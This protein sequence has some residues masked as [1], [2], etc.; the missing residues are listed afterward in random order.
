MERTKAQESR[1][2][3]ERLYI[4]MRHLFNRGY[5]KPSGESGKAIINALLTL[6]PEIYGSMAE[7]EKVELEGLVYAIDRLPKGIEECRF[8]TL[9]SDEGLRNASFEVI[10]PSKR[11]RNCFRID[12][13]QMFIEVTRG[14]SEIYDILAH[15]T[16][17]FVEAR[18]I[19]EKALDAK[20]EKTREWLKIE[21]IVKGGKPEDELHDK[22]IAF[23]YLGTV[24]ARTYDEVEKAYARFQESTGQNSG[25]FHVIYWL[26]KL[27]I[28]EESLGRDRKINFS[29]SLRERIGHH[30]YGERWAANIKSSLISHKLF[31]R[32]LHIISANL[33][34]VMNSLYAVGALGKKYKDIP[35]EEIAVTLSKRENGHLREKVEDYAKRH[36]LVTLSDPFGTNIGV[37]IIDTSKLNLAQL[38][39]ELSFDK[40]YLQ[41]ESPVIFVMDYAFG[42]QAF[43]TMDELLKPHRTDTATLHLN[44]RSIAVMGKAGILTGNKGDIML[45][46]AH[47]F[48]GTSDNYPFN[49]DLDPEDFKGR[50]LEVM[51]GTML[52]VLGTSLQNKDVLRYFR[53]SS[54]NTVGLEMEGAHYQK[55]IQAAAKIRHSISPDVAL[56]YAY[57]ASDNPL[58]TGHSLASGSL[59]VIGVRPTYLITVNFLNKIL[60][61]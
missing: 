56:R 35:L 46:T 54:W 8:I 55:A 61:Q 52:T 36:G 6:S 58:M 59:G 12:E 32:P 33:H 13:E 23:T 20:G 27:A 10:T 1:A 50:G 19:K 39:K 38:P 2:A 31:D 5:Y 16:F 40:E 28:E 53:N 57:Y 51:E 4:T 34:S 60:N 47:I 26:G 3:I 11:R 49:N 24:L 21:E 9:T 25:L 18:K 41:Q 37:Q 14:R 30:I 48:E 17:L 44:A 15:L 7:A 45:P 29:P 43:E 42:E 22:E